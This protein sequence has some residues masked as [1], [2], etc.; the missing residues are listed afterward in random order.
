MGSGAVSKRCALPSAV[1]Q[2]E[3]RA[4]H[5]SWHSTECVGSTRHSALTG[6]SN[7]PNH[8]SHLWT[9][10]WAWAWHLTT[11]AL[12]SPHARSVCSLAQ[13]PFDS[14]STPANPRLRFS[15]ASAPTYWHWPNACTS[16]ITAALSDSHLMRFLDKEDQI[17][18]QRT[19]RIQNSV[20]DIHV[21]WNKW[22]N[23]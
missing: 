20:G 4:A 18:S 8:K 15:R 13:I 11:P 7:F 6:K 22:A 10:T 1:T 2:L 23:D 5:L 9:C 17:W 19:M 14:S 12:A 21:A 16:N 3:W